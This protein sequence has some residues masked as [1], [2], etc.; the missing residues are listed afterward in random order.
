MKKRII[1]YLII[2]LFLI[3]GCNKEAGMDKKYIEETASHVAAE[4]M[5]V[6]EDIDFVVTNV[7]I[8]NDDVGAAFVDGYVKGDEEKRMFVTV[9]YLDDFKVGGY[10]ELE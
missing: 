8:T 5:L 4:Y 10:G 1:F 7:Q 3:S 9:D 6:E 2:S